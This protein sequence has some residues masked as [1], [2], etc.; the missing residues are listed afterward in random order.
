[1][2]TPVLTEVEL[3]VRIVGDIHGQ[4]YDLLRIFD[5]V[6]RPPKESFVFLGNYVDYGP[7][8]VETVTLLLIYKILYPEKIV[9]LRGNHE[10]PEVN[11]NCG[12]RDECTRRYSPRLW[13]IFNDVFAVL[14]LA[15]SIGRKILAV[16]GGMSPAVTDRAALVA[17]ERP[18]SSLSGPVADMLCSNPDPDANEWTPDPSGMGGAF[19]LSRVHTWLDGFEHEI[20]VRGNDHAPG[21]LEFPFEPDRSVVTLFSAPCYKTGSEN[22][23]SVMTVN[24]FY[25]CSFL[26][27]KPVER[28]MA[29]RR[30]LTPMQQ[31]DALRE[32]ATR[33]K[34]ARGT[35][36]RNSLTRTK[37]DV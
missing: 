17:L 35:P 1:M 8:C 14:P 5:V 11:E 4:F 16:H 22:A 9:I 12:F 23:G 2:K 28:R 25:E 21:G 34:R 13:N 31:I 36:M 10:C 24:T 27:I 26:T 20:M 18:L 37:K 32:S 33:P 29:G 6:G 30:E 3:P 7:Q 19:S 15:A